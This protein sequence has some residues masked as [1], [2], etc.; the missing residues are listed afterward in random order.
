M[1]GGSCRGVMLLLAPS[2]CLA[3][4]GRF[5]A[6]GGWGF[7]CR[8]GWL[9]VAALAINAITGFGRRVGALRQCSQ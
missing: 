2:G 4:M 8:S 7:C 3:V 9:G 1:G 6:R 5:T